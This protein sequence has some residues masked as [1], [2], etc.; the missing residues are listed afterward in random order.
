MLLTLSITC[1]TEER[2]ETTLYSI[3]HRIQADKTYFDFR[4]F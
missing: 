2:H 4:S 3:E 1:L